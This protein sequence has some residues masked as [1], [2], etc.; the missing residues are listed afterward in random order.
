MIKRRL[1][2]RRDIVQEGINILQKRAEKVEKA[3][4][5]IINDLLKTMIVPKKSR[6]KNINSK[7]IHIERVA[8][9]DSTDD[10]PDFKEKLTKGLN[11]LNEQYPYI[12]FKYE[13]AKIRKYKKGE[14]DYRNI[15][16]ASMNWADFY[17]HARS[18]SSTSSSFQKLPELG[19][20]QKF[21]ET[22]ENN[23]NLIQNKIKSVFSEVNKHMTMSQTD[24]KIELVKNSLIQEITRDHVNMLVNQIRNQYGSII[25][26]FRD[27]ESHNIIV[28]RIHWSIYLDQLAVQKSTDSNESYNLEE[29]GKT[30]ES[31]KHDHCN[32]ELLQSLEST[33]YPP[34]E[35]PKSK[36]KKKIKKSE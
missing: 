24:H 35:H 1:S 7:I 12:E 14:K 11:E 3:N 33:T 18:S 2:K 34:L 22:N 17:R 25:E 5:K 15:L 10:F 13:I 31:S 23:T 9:H 6:M 20:S 26:I 28:L 36:K 27:A 16:V 4:N 30:P 21:S 32:I 8:L 19:L 29:F